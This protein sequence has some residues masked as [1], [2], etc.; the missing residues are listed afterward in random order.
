MLFLTARLTYEFVLI[1]LPH[2]LIS[3]HRKYGL[4]LRNLVLSQLVSLPHIPLLL[5]QYAWTTINMDFWWS[6]GILHGS[7][8][9][10]SCLP[11]G[12]GLL[13]LILAT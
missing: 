8:V 9:A 13:N 4:W 6:Y 12:A 5:N 7:P 11:N 2:A 3:P 1:D 10:Y